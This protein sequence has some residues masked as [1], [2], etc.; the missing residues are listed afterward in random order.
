MPQANAGGPLV[1]YS[2]DISRGGG[3]FLPTASHFYA[4]ECAPPGSV[5]VHVQGDGGGSLAIH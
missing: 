3:L 4:R 2:L 1:E 5:R